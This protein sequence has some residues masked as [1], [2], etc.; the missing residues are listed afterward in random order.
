MLRI[1]CFYEDIYLF[2]AP[3]GTL[4][5]NGKGKN[6]FGILKVQGFMAHIG[7]HL[8]TTLFET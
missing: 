2:I 4:Q 5:P 6:G 3:L 1:S 8:R 7:G